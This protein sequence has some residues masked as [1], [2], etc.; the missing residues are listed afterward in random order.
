MTM[1]ENAGSDVGRLEAIVSELERLWAPAP[2][3]EGYYALAYAL[4]LH[5]L[6]EHSQHIRDRVN[7]LLKAVV[8][9][10]PEDFLAW[11]YLGHNAYDFG[12][13]SA[14]MQYFR[15]AC[16]RA[17]NDYL[18]LKALEFLAASTARQRG[19]AAAISPI[20]RLAK[21][22]ETA[23]KEDVW[24]QELGKVLEQTDFLV[25]EDEAARLRDA[26]R[27]LDRAGRSAS[28]LTSLARAGLARGR[29]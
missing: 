1:A 14:A 27:R 22:A 13:Y 24:P 19:L 23:E 12:Q 8:E 7:E 28:W 4:Y 10:R 3:P 29:G 5:P 16:E 9:E 6:R 15:E 18:G 21:A 11:L 17:K 20:E 25:S 2:G 26:V